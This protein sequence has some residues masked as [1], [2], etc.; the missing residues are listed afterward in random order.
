M[1]CL[2]KE[3]ENGQP[4]AFTVRYATDVNMTTASMGEVKTGKKT[5]AAS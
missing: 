2:T 3:D 5:D 1:C 4:W